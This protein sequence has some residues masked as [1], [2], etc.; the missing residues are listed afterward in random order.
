MS[1]FSR[2]TGLRPSQ[3]LGACIARWKFHMKSE[4]VG[5]QSHGL[6]DGGYLWSLSIPRWNSAMGVGVCA[7]FIGMVGGTLVATS[8]LFQ[9]T[10]AMVVVWFSLLAALIGVY[11]FAGRTIWP[12]VALAAV[13]DGLIIFFRADKHKYD[14]VGVVVPWAE[15]T[16]LGYEA[17]RS[18]GIMHTLV[19]HLCA[20]S[21]VPL[22]QIS[23]RAVKDTLYVN[24]FSEKIATRAIDSLT[25]FV[26]RNNQSH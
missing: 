25:Q 21:S 18:D 23:F 16:S 13:N 5:D 11:S 24:V 10:I 19:V 17:Y 14:S 15:I 12:P 2:R 20:N 4:N 22:D 26:P 1:F 9:P 7:G 3:E 8:G 6:P